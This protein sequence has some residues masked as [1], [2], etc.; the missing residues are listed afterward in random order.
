L[1]FLEPRGHQ[2]RGFFLCGL[3]L[4]R[5]IAVNVGLHRSKNSAKLL[6]RN[7]TLTGD[8]ALEWVGQIPRHRD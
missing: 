4:G 2:P 7:F 8:I 6:K 1:N 3:R 5:L